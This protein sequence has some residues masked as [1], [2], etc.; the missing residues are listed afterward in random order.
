M[1]DPKIQAIKISRLPYSSQDTAIGILYLKGAKL[2]QRQHGI[3][4]R[5]FERTRRRRREQQRVPDDGH[6]G[7]RLL[8]RAARG[9]RARTLHQLRPQVGH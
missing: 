4:E 3:P 2:I 9:P 8:H 7:V 6:D 1:R 5:H